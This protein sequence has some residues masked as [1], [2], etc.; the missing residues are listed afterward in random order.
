MHFFNVN[1][2]ISINISLKFVPKGPI[3]NIPVLVQMMAL[4]RLI[5]R[6]YI[7]FYT[8]SQQNLIAFYLFIYLFIFFHFWNP[9]RQNSQERNVILTI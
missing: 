1:I 2:Q 6:I 7:T 4:T 5:Y 8:F 3:Y 9:G